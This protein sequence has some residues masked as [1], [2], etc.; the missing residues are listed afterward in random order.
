MQELTRTATVVEQDTLADSLAVA[1][2]RRELEALRDAGEPAQLWLEL[3]R[4]GNGGPK[5]LTI[6]I[7]TSDIE[8]LL[9][10]PNGDDLLIALDGYA[11][12]G[13]FDDGDVEAHG[14]RSALAIA[15]VVAGMAA[16]AGL[17]ANPQSAS[18]QAANPAASAQ[19]A[20]PAASAQ[21]ANPAASAQVSKAAS[22]VQGSN[23]AS[24]AQASNPAASAQVAKAASKVQGSNPASRAQAANPAARAQAAKAAAKAQ[25]S[26][27]GFRW[28]AAGVR[29]LAR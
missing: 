15:V 3:E 27:A 28:S 24:R 10:H 2:P 13:L 11:L 21:A 5:L 20:N 8:E 17:A 16:P 26:A 18:A 25:I 4:E 14:L 23:P 22:T 7:T 9:Q 6:D 19:A 29:P 1:F 12:S